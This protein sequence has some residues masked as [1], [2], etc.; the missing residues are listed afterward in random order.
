[1]LQ[2]MG[3]IVLDLFKLVETQVG[4]RD[5]ENIPGFGMLVDKNALPRFLEL[6]FDLEQPLAFEHDGQNKSGGGVTGLV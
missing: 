3:N 6:L 1:V 5:R 2:Q 4:V